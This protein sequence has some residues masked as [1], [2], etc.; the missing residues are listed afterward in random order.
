MRRAITVVWMFYSVSAFAAVFEFSSEFRRD[1]LDAEEQTNEFFR[2]KAKIHS[3]TGISAGAAFSCTADRRKSFTWNAEFDNA[4]FPIYVIA[5]NFYAQEGS[6]LLYGRIRP[7]NPDPLAIESWSGLKSG[8]CPCDSSNPAYSFYG[9]GVSLYAGKKQNPIMIVSAAHSR[10]V[11][12]IS[13]SA[14]VKDASEISASSI[15][16]R[17][18]KD[19]SGEQPVICSTSLGSLS[20][21]PVQFV[22]M[23]CACMAFSMSGEGGR[24]LSWDFDETGDTRTAKRQIAALSYSLSYNDGVVK[25]F[26]EAA[27]C[28]TEYMKND[29]TVYRKGYAYQGEV[30]Y[31]S[32]AA[33]FYA[34]GKLIGSEF[35][36]PFMSSFGSR[37][38]SNGFFVGLKISPFEKISAE[39]DGSAE[40]YLP[41]SVSGSECDA[42]VRESICIK[43]KV[44]DRISVEASYRAR[45]D[46]VSAEPDL[47]QERINL[48]YRW[49]SGSVH[50]GFAEQ[51]TSKKLAYIVSPGMEILSDEHM[52]T[53]GAEGIW[54]K[55]GSAYLSSYGD[56][57]DLRTVEKKECIIRCGYVYSSGV[58]RGRSEVSVEIGSTGF[59]GKRIMFEICS[60]L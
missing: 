29:M 57:Q 39:A 10:C 38:P 36:T 44:W 27:V 23:E 53:A 49:R 54:A 59:R 9:A 7:Y 42:V 11:R 6:G 45:S 50:V 32:D 5:G 46:T 40:K 31:S 14:S 37:S 25:S 17:Y 51:N 60:V 52:F 22:R 34:R 16:S 13:A 58:L 56:N 47:N 2:E 3:E 12:Y 33:S 48:R 55:K 8:F 1:A 21:S 43:G 41:S 35:S 18:I 20:F 19:K 15:L 30:S 28:R 4:D 26:L 24:S